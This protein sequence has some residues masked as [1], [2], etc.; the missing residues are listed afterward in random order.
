MTG[1]QQYA[2]TARYSY[3]EVISLTVFLFSGKDVLRM[4]NSPFSPGISDAK[5]D[6]NN[7]QFLVGVCFFFI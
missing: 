6:Y 2:E 5:R 4:A 7:P 1:S 3:S